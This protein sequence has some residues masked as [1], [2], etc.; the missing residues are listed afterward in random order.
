MTRFLVWTL[1]VL[2][3]VAVVTILLSRS[4]ARQMAVAEASERS[5]TFARIAVAPLVDERLLAGDAEAT[6]AFVRL[7]ESRMA[8]GS[9]ERMKV[10]TEDGTVLWSD[11]PSVIGQTFALEPQVAAIFGTETISAEVS[12]LDR[13]EHAHQQESTSL[14]EV[15]VGFRSADGVPLA[16]EA[17]WP[18]DRLQ[19][20]STAIQIRFTALALGAMLLP[21]LALLP[22]ARSLAR[23]VDRG[24]VE[25]EELMT[26]ALAASDLERRRL[27]QV[28]HD[29]IVQDLV[30]L[31]YTLPVV[32]SALPAEAVSE[33]ELVDQI[34][35]DVDRAVTGARD[36]LTDVYPA[37]L[38]KGGLLQAVE[39]LADR[40]RRDGVVVTTD[41][42]PRLGERPP[43]AR[44]TYRVAREG[45]R[46]AAKHAHAEGVEVSAVVEGGRAVIRVR[47]DGRGPGR[48]LPLEAGSNGEG[49]LGLHLLRD[50]LRTLGGSLSLRDD[51]VGGA[52]LEATFPVPITVE[53]PGWPARSPH[54]S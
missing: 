9:I 52:V 33:R 36:L 2:V 16:Y 13:A 21:A 53:A 25:R 28:L 45:L 47:D 6:T 7:M 15:Y 42:D 40:L 37:D 54:G 10:W 22:L 26:Q 18:T 51:P 11:D 8:D 17:Y 43:E 23:R 35:A 14:I 49:H 31:G 30:A 29:G 24:L 27:S 5:E 1:L 19:L 41:L 46:N 39:A 12:T 50:T 38:E 3:I 20:N 32:A 48:A 44:V 34:R 4:L